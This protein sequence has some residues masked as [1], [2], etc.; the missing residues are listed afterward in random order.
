ME[1]LVRSDR[2]PDDKVGVQ[3]SPLWLLSRISIWILWMAAIFDP[4]GDLRIRYLALFLSVICLCISGAFLDIFSSRVELRLLFVRYSL[5]L[6]PIWGSL[7]Y[8]LRSG[9]NDV[10]IDT[11]YYAS[12]VLALISLIYRDI[13][14]VRYSI[15][16]M[17]FSLR[18]LVFVVIFAQISIVFN[19]GLDWIQF[20]IDNNA[21]LLG[22][23][24]YAE[25]TFPYIYFFASPVLVFLCAHEVDCLSRRPGFLHLLTALAALLALALTGTRAHILIAVSYLPFFIFMKY[26]KQKTLWLG[27]SLLASFVYLIFYGSDLLESFVS[28]Q[29]ES[30]ALKVSFI[31]KYFLIFDDFWSFIFGQGFNAHAWSGTFRSMIA[32]DIGASKTELTY[33]EVIRSFGIIVGGGYLVLLVVIVM[34]AYALSPHL[35]W[36]FPALVVFLVDCSLNPYL[37]ST[38]GILPLGLV[39]GAIAYDPR[40]KK[41]RVEK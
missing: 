23:R 15:S 21:A 24:T 37:F 40:E 29:D 6:M 13:N 19:L 20:F 32:F 35:R 31:S 4:V 2:A 30:N 7:L 34:R 8:V 22:Q 25:V 38:N 33:L 14:L 16:A 11:S 10:F 17:L 18:L 39:L 9:F 27:F 1:A 41:K 26:G 5:F 12:A 28:L 36:L 3:F